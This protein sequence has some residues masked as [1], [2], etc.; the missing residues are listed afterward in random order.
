MA[1]KFKVIK[2]KHFQ[3]QMKRLPMVVHKEVEKAIKELAKNPKGANTM[4]VFGEPS[5]KE[6]RNW[7]SGVSVSNVDAVLEYLH[8]KNCLTV[9]GDKLA[10]E[11]WEEYIKEK[12]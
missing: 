1:N 4:S 12:K 10:H 11:F 2:T 7:M 9:T 5:A 6:L 3:E 8:D